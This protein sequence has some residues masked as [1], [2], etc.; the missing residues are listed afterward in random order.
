MT[1]LRGWNNRRKA[2]WSAGLSV[3]LLGISLASCWVYLGFCPHTSLS[4]LDCT[5][6]HGRFQLSLISV[7]REMMAALE[8]YP[9]LQKER[10][11]APLWNARLLESPGLRWRF[12]LDVSSD[13]AGDRWFSVFIPLWV[14]VALAFATTAFLWWRVQRD[15][16]GPRHC[17]KCG[18]SL[19]G[20]AA[21]A[22]CPECGSTR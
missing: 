5:I 17:P 1:L 11:I 13:P 20:L 2:K 10:D 7:S 6:E 19:A 16:S 3:L 4:N 12:Y 21:G 22:A 18:Y 8:R 15:G 14:P 9:D